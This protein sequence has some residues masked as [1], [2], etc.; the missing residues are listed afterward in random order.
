MPP[1]NFS[2]NIWGGMLWDFLHG[3]ASLCGPQ[4]A[5]RFAALLHSLSF[6]L[7]CDLC[8]LD[9]PRALKQLAEERGQSPAQ[10]CA[11][12]EAQAFV[13]DLHDAV[14]MKL[15]R[16]RYADLAREFGLPAEASP[17]ALRTIFPGLSTPSLL[18]KSSLLLPNP[19]HT[20]SLGVLLLILC[21]RLQSFVELQQFLVFLDTAAHM[22]ARVEQASLD[23]A[24]A[25]GRWACAYRVL[26]AKLESCQMPEQ[27]EA[28][29]PSFYR[30][31][32]CAFLG[33]ALSDAE[34]AAL[35]ARVAMAQSGWA[36]APKSDCAVGQGG[37]V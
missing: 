30:V 7:P 4:D 27:Q 24:R 29:A 17:H 26:S 21:S 33:R 25:A 31:M 19:F 32:R 6:L 14:N 22:L 34:D 36:A 8:L 16:Q 5:S 1:R 9:Y 18:R 15:A 20:E 13:H 10:A 11:R 23:A 28:V 35:V 2:A 3:A 37:C 12:G